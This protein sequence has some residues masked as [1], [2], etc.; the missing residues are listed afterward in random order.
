MAGIP[1]AVESLRVKSAEK[2]G[3]VGTEA[4][5]GPGTDRIAATR[6]VVDD[7]RISTRPVD[8]DDESVAEHLFD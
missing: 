6:P 1:F 4:T 2:F 8:T 5:L 3:V 7:G